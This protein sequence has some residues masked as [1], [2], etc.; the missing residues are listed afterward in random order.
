LRAQGAAL[1][2]PVIQTT[3]TGTFSSEIP[4]PRL[5]LLLYAFTRVDLWSK[6]LRSSNV[7]VEMPFYPETWVTN[8]EGEVLAR[9]P[10][11]V[12]GYARSEVTLPDSPPFSH[13]AQ[14]PYGIS[15]FAYLFDRLGNALLAPRYRRQVRRLHGPR[16][17]PMDR[18]TKG[19]RLALLMVA[20][21]AFLLGRWFGRGDA[22]S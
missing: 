6:L 12:E 20:G 11:G 9:V 14:P 22:R 17:A 4:R 19:W 13:G 1:G 10:P 15:P 7:R 2:V 16:M 18:R 8:A 3:A 5:S 21:L